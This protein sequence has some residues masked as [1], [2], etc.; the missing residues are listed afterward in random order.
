[1][2][3]LLLHTPAQIF[4]NTQLNTRIPY[5][6]KKYNQI[7]LITQQL[8]KSLLYQKK[9]ITEKYFFEKELCDQS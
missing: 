9:Q 8:V 1:M 3:N 5:T 4:Y 7:T 2:A 6:T